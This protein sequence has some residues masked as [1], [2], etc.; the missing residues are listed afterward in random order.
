VGQRDEG[1]VDH[2]DKR[3]DHPVG[4]QGRPPGLLQPLLGAFAL[5]GGHAA[6][7]DANHD[8][9]EEALVAGNTGQRLDALVAC[10]DVTGQKAKPG[11]S[12]GAKDDCIQLAKNPING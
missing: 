12:D 6:Q 7:E 5:H 10:I 2:L 3:P 8:G 11:S 9:G 4:L 1:E